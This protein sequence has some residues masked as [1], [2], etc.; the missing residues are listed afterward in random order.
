MRRCILTIAFLCLL[1]SGTGC[2]VADELD[3]GE[4][5]MNH[6]SARAKN[7][8]PEPAQTAGNESGSTLESLRNMSSGAFGSMKEKIEEATKK[9][10]DPSNTIVQCRVDGRTEFKRKYDCQSLG[11]R[12]VMR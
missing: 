2:F 7:K 8:K 1:G 6:N 4:Q 5:I 12:I 10:P 3:S 11:G 9:E